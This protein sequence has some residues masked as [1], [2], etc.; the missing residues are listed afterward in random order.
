MNLKYFFEED[1]YDI[2]Y[3][4]GDNFPDDPDI[5]IEPSMSLIIF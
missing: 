1:Q 3:N 5:G 4:Y 2:Y